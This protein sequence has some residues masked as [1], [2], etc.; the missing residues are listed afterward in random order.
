MSSELSEVRSDAVEKHVLQEE[1]VYTESKHST[2][3]TE[4]PSPNSS[5]Q[6][7]IQASCW[8]LCNVSR[9]VSLHFD[10]YD[11]ASPE[12]DWTRT[13][14]DSSGAET[15]IFLHALGVLN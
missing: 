9:D 10:A 6:G 11:M 4:Q 8:L 15:P 14:P 13:I 2:L 5:S 3:E 12:P 7:E 1:V